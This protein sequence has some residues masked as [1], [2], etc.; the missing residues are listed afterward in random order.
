MAKTTAI[1]KM[2]S[3]QKDVAQ[4]ISVLVLENEE[5]EKKIE[6]YEKTMFE[7]L[8]WTKAYPV[9]AFP[10]PDFAHVQ[11]LIGAQLL[12]EVSA[13]NMRR[14]VQGIEKMVFDC[15]GATGHTVVG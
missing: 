10:E 3:D 15:L 9:Q 2:L 6:V 14:V 12:T 8:N 11:E 1:E 5:L 7:L 13:S 4:E